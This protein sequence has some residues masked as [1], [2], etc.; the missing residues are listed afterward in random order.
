MG[1]NPTPLDNVN[2]LMLSLRKS[3]RLIRY[4]R[5]SNRAQSFGRGCSAEAVGSSLG[6]VC[7]INE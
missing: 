6:R 5:A 3:N 2:R 4:E 1:C 7:K